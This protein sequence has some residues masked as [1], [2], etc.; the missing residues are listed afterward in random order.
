M[1]NVGV[2]V[3]PLR[4]APST[5]SAIAGAAGVL[6]QVVGEALDVE[7]ELLGVAARG[8]GLQRVLVVE[9]QVV[10]RPERV[11]GGGGLGGLGR[12]LGVGVH[13]G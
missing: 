6:A 2:P 4:S 1:K 7:P 8:R 11:L 10:H 13:V 12:E 3:T 5:S 9:E